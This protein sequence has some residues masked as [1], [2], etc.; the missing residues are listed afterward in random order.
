MTL[1][2]HIKTQQ[3]AINLIIYL[4]IRTFLNEII[5]SNKLY[6]ILIIFQTLKRVFF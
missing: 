4:N 5:L 1:E 2:F 3:R 6:L